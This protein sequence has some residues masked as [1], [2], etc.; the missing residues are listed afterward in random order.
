MFYFNYTSPHTHCYRTQNRTGH[1]TNVVSV[2]MA[3]I[4]SLISQSMT[5]YL[6]AL[7]RTPSQAHGCYTHLLSTGD[8]KE[9]NIENNLP[10]GF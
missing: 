4:L 2:T 8:I 1:R 9:E 5:F 3:N 6:V 10:S 7:P